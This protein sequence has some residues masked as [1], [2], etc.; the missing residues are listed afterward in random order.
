[1]TKIKDDKELNLKVGILEDK[2]SC[3]IEKDIKWNKFVG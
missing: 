1:M 3:L 2:A